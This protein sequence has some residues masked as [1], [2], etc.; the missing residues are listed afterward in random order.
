MTAHELAHKLLAGPDLPVAT[1]EDETGTTQLLAG[2]V[3]V[4]PE[5]HHL[6]DEDWEVDPTWPKGGGKFEP[7]HTGQ[8][9]RLKATAPQR[10]VVVI[11]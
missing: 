8:P 4:D 6:Y 7:R 2:N 1:I 3:Y 10:G 9:H 5:A 11:D